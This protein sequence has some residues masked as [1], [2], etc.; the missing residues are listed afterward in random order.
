MI[1]SRPTGNRPGYYGHSSLQRPT[2]AAINSGY[3][4]GYNNSY[5]SYGQLRAA[6]ATTAAT[7]R[8][9]RSYRRL[10]TDRGP[11]AFRKRFSRPPGK[12]PGA[13]WRAS[14]R[15]RPMTGLRER[16]HSGGHITKPSLIPARRPV[17]PGTNPALQLSSA[18]QL[19]SRQAEPIMDVDERHS[20]SSQ[21][22]QTPPPTASTWKRPRAV[23]DG[24]WAAR[25][26]AKNAG[27]KNRW[28]FRVP[29]SSGA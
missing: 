20:G 16:N 10:L 8:A 24:P 17:A 29:G 14:N 18:H 2:T 23:A 27:A 25:P 22:R 1:A 3:N 19:V 4:S 7:G 5:G 9:Y 21:C 13:H 11:G 12:P 26:T 15:G 28:D 6:T